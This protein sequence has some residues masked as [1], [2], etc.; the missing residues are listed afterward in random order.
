MSGFLAGIWLKTAYAEGE[1]KA[2][3][4][5]TLKPARCNKWASE[6]KCKDRKPIKSKH[7]TQPLPSPAYPIYS[8]GLRRSLGGGGRWEEGRLQSQ[9][10]LPPHFMDEETKT[11]GGSQMGSLKVA[12]ALS[13]SAGIWRSNVGQCLKAHICWKGHICLLS[14]TDI[15]DDPTLS[16]QLFKMFILG[17]VIRT[18]TH[19]YM[20]NSDERT[21]Y[22]FGK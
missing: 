16:I 13:C 15:S 11:Q 12:Q 20:L 14:M 22:P 8:K 4:E 17:T 1:R 21:G 19:K 5:K 9:E 6:H 10:V 3:N 7:S 18:Q 2:A